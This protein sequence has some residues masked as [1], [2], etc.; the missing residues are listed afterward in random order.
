MERER[1]PH[2]AKPKPDRRGGGKAALLLLFLFAVIAL[3]LFFRSDLSKIDTIDVTGIR[4][5][6]LA[7]VRQAIG[8]AEGD[9]F[10]AAT[11]RTLTE[12]A[13]GLPNVEEAR[14]AK[15]FPGRIVI[16]IR[17]YPEVAYLIG[18]DGEPRALLS[19]GRDVPVPEG[20]PVRNLPIL[21]GWEPGSELLRRMA[22]VLAG[23]PAHLL[24]DISQIKPEP[25]DAWPDRIRM[26]TR[27]C[28]EVVTTIGYLPDRLDY[29]RAIIDEYEPGIITMLEANTHVPYP[30]KDGSG[31]EPDA[32]GKP[33]SAAD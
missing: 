22:E 26:Y 28:F 29:M 16:E 18:P 13:A 27:S 3:I 23:L 7:D 32:A 6:P 8:V 20:E 31:G 24:A 25:A 19:S 2:L 11:A 30:P 14:V 17:E 9:S 1:V 21:S 15:R 33:S 4:H 12:R 5:T 10:F